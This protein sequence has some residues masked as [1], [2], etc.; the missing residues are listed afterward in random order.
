MQKGRT[1]SSFDLWACL[2]SSASRNGVRE[3]ARE[4][5]SLR[6]H[7]L[8]CEGQAPQF[9]FTCVR[10]RPKAASISTTTAKLSFA[11]SFH[12][13]QSLRLSLPTDNVNATIPPASLACHLT[14]SHPDFEALV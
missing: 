14:T 3:T 7:M 5:R 4:S 6:D 9:T 11:S 12:F 1:P 2:A 10:V 13:N 8:A